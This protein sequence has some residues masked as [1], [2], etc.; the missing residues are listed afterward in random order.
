LLLRWRIVV[1]A[2]DSS[3]AR[4]SLAVAGMMLLHAAIASADSINLL[5]ATPA[6]LQA[7]V[8]DSVRL[9]GSADELSALVDERCMVVEDR[10]RDARARP[11]TSR[12][13]PGQAAWLWDTPTDQFPYVICLD[14]PSHQTAL[15]GGLNVPAALM[16]L[17]RS[18]TAARR[19]AAVESGHD[20]S[21]PDVIVAI[22]PTGPRLL[23]WPVG[24][25]PTTPPDEPPLAIDTF[26]MD[27]PTGWSE[28]AAGLAEPAGG[29]GYPMFASTTAL[30]PLNSLTPAE[31]IPAPEPGTWLLVA[32]GLAAAWR[33]RRR[34]SAQR[35]V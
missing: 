5:R 14:S 35:E 2:P 26:A 19:P 29:N 17:Q 21:A 15:G 32:T 33:A 24:G 31:T 10:Q 18:S 1:T 16:W 13:P 12:L 8:F 3:P 7:I 22:P 11:G 28:F 23:W 27:A 25:P 34:S 4:L 9:D 30:D 6:S 20:N